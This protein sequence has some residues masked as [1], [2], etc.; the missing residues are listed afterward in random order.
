MAPTY[1]SVLDDTRRLIGEHL[2]DPID[3]EPEHRFD[4]DLQLGSIEVMDL[5]ADIED[6]FDITIPLND[7]PGMQTV[8]DT[9]RHLLRLIENSGR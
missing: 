3:V 1:E 5:V 6:H 8:G 2:T 9:A 4:T 7:L